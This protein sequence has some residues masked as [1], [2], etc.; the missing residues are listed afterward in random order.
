MNV[1][2]LDAL[3]ISNIAQTEFLRG[4]FPEALFQSNRALDLVDQVRQQYSNPLLGASY[5]SSTHHYYAEHIAL[6]L[7]LH[8]RQPTAGYDVKAFQTSEPAQPRALL[9]SL[10]DLGADLRADVPAALT[11]REAS[12]Q[13]ALDNIISERDKVARTVASATKS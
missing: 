8:A 5:S 6:L 4:N 13:K 11:E 3:S 1:K 9:E 10:S 2:I 12:L 7:K